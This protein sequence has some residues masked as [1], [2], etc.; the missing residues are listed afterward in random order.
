MSLAQ[1]RQIDLLKKR[2]SHFEGQV[3]HL[4]GQ[5]AEANR[6]LDLLLNNF[7]TTM[8]KAID[9]VIADGIEV[10]QTTDSQIKALINE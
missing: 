6:K 7:E 5:V 9:K 2:V 8:A 1:Q 3:S 10:E 4:E